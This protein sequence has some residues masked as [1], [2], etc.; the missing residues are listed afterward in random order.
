[1]QQEHNRC[2][3]TQL[4]KP[5]KVSI[6]ERYVESDSEEPLGPEELQE[7]SRRAERIRTLI[8]KSR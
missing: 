6:P 7:R 2:L 4:S 3:S 5:R 8:A 1:M